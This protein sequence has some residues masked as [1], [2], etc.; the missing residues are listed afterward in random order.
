MIGAVLTEPVLRRFRFGPVVE[1][2]VRVDKSALHFLDFQT[3]NVL[4]NSLKSFD[5][6]Q[7]T[8][9]MNSNGIDVCVLPLYR[10][11]VLE[12]GERTNQQVGQTL[13]G[14]NSRCWFAPARAGEK[15]DSITEDIETLLKHAKGQTNEEYSVLASEPYWFETSDGARGVVQISSYFNTPGLAQIRSATSCCT[16]T[17]TR[18]GGGC[19]SNT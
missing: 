3:G 10:M 13:V 12:S 7:M 11:E 2:V 16:I 18:T 1:R 15:F 17:T 14:F 6:Q 8:S 5:S 19:A 4:T 9:W